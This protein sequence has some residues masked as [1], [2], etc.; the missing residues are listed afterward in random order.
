MS[1]S[2]AEA[3]TE[4]PSP[5]EA[6]VIDEQEEG[7]WVF[8]D[9]DTGTKR[10]ASPLNSHQ[11]ARSTP[12]HLSVFGSSYTSG[13]IEPF[14][15]GANKKERPKGKEIHVEDVLTAAKNYNVNAIHVVG[16]NSPHRNLGKADRASRGVSAEYPEQFSRGVTS[17][18]PHRFSSKENNGDDVLRRN[19]MSSRLASTPD[20]G[21]KG[22]PF[23]SPPSSRSPFMS[24]SPAAVS[25]PQWQVDQETGFQG[26]LFVRLLS[27]HQCVR[28]C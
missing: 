6:S 27:Y 22:S 1:F 3:Q 14:G 11:T 24:F 7:K 16:G 2:S 12:T 21:R 9:P 13:S 15:N 17:S 8:G 28:V 23:F 26:E 20:R 5:D 19:A 10:Q 18:L 4:P 25:Q